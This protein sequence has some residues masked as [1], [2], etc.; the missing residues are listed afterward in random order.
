LAAR[1]S[2]LPTARFEAGLRCFGRHADVSLL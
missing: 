1:T 2:L